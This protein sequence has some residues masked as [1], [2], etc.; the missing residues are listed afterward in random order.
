MNTITKKINKNK[1]AV[2][3]EHV[4]AS[5]PLPV[6]PPSSSSKDPCNTGQ[7]LLMRSLSDPPHMPI[8]GTLEYDK[9]VQAR[10][11]L[12]DKIQSLFDV[13]S[14][15]LNTLLSQSDIDSC[16]K[17][18]GEP[19]SVELSIKRESKKA[20]I[21]SSAYDMLDDDGKR[22]L[23]KEFPNGSQPFL[24]LMPLSSVTDEGDEY[25]QKRIAAVDRLMN[26]PKQ[27]QEFKCDGS[28][29]CPK[30][31]NHNIF[32]SCDDVEFDSLLSRKRAPIDDEEST[33]LLV[34]RQKKIKVS[35]SKIDGVQLQASPSNSW[36]IKDTYIAVIDTTDTDSPALTGQHVSYK[37]VTPSPMLTRQQVSQANS[38][39]PH[40]I[41]K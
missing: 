2:N 12:L 37:D 22:E 33:S 5:Q 10:V 27:E 19:S 28:M 25:I 40:H 41:F 36:S 34:G 18:N 30:N 15:D 1:S 31:I 6:N 23:A 4:Y 21:I 8:A 17:V 11:N 39:N 7:V 29:H 38:P 32:H 35:C 16:S 14:K 20:K 9:S 24:N 3:Q 26:K 13:V